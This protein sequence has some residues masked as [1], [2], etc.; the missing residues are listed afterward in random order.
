MQFLPGSHKERIRWHRHIDNDPSVHGL[1]TD[2]V[3]PAGAVA[4]PIPAGGATFH[5]CRTMHYAGPNTTDRTRR[6]YI[7][8]FSAPQ[9]KRDVP[10]ERTMAK[11]GEG[12]AGKAELVGG[13]A[14]VRRDGDVG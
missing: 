6:A 5:H 13:A 10:E 1:V 11:R 3:E 12:S 8:V 9:Q 7:L 4:C 14:E 2:E